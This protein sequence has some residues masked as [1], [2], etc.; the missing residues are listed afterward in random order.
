MRALERLWL[1]RA[2]R[3][4]L[5]EQITRQLKE[6]I[7]RGLLGPGEALPSTRDLAADLKVSRNTVVYAY[8]RLLSEG[9]VEPRSRSGVFV[10]S[11]LAPAR[12]S[13]RALRGRTLS[14][15]GAE[16]AAP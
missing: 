13:G 3:T 10:N 8:D 4:T 14:G 11:S 15:P 1:D 9:Y 5:Q 12:P 7:Q 2:G 6:L 16:P